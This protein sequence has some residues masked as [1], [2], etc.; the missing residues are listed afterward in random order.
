MAS[1]R[2]LIVPRSM[3]TQMKNVV[4]KKSVDLTSFLDRGSVADAVVN[5]DSGVGWRKNENG[6]GQ[7]AVGQSVSMGSITDNQIIEDHDFGEINVAVSTSNVKSWK[8]RRA[9]N[10]AISRARGGNS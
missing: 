10:R 3:I 6:S 4:V 7:S 9:E 2:G 5:E 1:Y 8:Q